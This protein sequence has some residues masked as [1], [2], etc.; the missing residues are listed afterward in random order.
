MGFR[1]WMGIGLM[2]LAGIAGWAGAAWD[3]TKTWTLQG[4]V[5]GDAEALYKASNSAEALENFELHNNDGFSANDVLL[6]VVGA[7]GSLNRVVVKKGE[8]FNWLVETGPV[9]VTAVGVQVGRNK[10]ASGI[11]SWDVVGTN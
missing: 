8:T 10:R 7:D 11:F 3:D 1:R 6:I 9:Q 2:G 4:G 5:Q